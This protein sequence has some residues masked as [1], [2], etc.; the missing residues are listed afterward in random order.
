[1]QYVLVMCNCEK[2][3][4]PVLRCSSGCAFDC[5]VFACYLP[6]ALAVLDRI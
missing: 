5:C 1:M 4:L 2:C 6:S 3:V